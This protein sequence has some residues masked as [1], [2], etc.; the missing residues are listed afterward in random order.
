M[1]DEALIACNEWRNSLSQRPLWQETIVGAE[2]LDIREID[3]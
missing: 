1:Q 2:E 3:A